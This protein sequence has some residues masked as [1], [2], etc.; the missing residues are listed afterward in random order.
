MA[1]RE[2]LTERVPYNYTHKKQSGG[3]GQ[4]GKIIGYIEPLTEEL[5][6]EDD[7]DE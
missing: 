1:Y 7:E 4:Y 5:L 2:T 3:A 6:Y